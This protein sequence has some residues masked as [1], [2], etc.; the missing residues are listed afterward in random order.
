MNILSQN[1]YISNKTYNKVLG[2]EIEASRTEKQIKANKACLISYHKKQIELISEGKITEPKIRVRKN[3]GD[4]PK[5]KKRAWE[6]K[7]DLYVY[8]LNKGLI[9]RPNIKKLAEYVIIFNEDTKRY[10][11]VRNAFAYDNLSYRA[12]PY[13]KYYTP[14]F[15]RCSILNKA[16]KQRRQDIPDLVGMPLECCF[17]SIFNPETIIQDAIIQKYGKIEY[18]KYYDNSSSSEDGNY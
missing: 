2:N 16:I 1:K 9:K 11:K 8:A 14:D 4:N 7:R 18:D 12:D 6:N 3:I 15:N 5:D 10:E 17:D 13:A